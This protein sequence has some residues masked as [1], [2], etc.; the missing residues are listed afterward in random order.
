MANKKS[1]SKVIGSILGHK[2]EKTTAKYLH[3]SDDAMSDA[4]N[5]I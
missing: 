1:N 4:V 5:A 3:P 2:N